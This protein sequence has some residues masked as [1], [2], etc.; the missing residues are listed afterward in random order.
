MTLMMFTLS[1]LIACSC[2][3]CSFSSSELLVAFFLV[4]FLPQ[5]CC[6]FFADSFSLTECHPMYIDKQKKAPC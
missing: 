3:A 1:S 4:P 6:C 2:F 5:N